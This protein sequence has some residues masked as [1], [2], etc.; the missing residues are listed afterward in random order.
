MKVEFD[1]SEFMRE[2]K[3][4]NI[5][6]PEELGYVADADGDNFGIKWDVRSLLSIVAI[7]RQVSLQRKT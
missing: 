4:S 3:C 2:T 1:I 7:N 6:D 5:V